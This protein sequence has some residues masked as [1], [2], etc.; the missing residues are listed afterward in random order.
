MKWEELNNENQ[1]YLYWDYLA[2][3]PDDEISFEEFNELMEGIT[4]S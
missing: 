4:V 2:A 1:I 3:N